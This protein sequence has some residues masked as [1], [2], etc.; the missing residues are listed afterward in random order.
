M[1]NRGIT[2]WPRTSSKQPSSTR[3]VA[4][5]RDQPSRR[6][7]LFGH[8]REETRKSIDKNGESST[9]PGDT[10][11]ER[12]AM[13]FPAMSRQL[14]TR[15]RKL[16]ADHRQLLLRCGSPSDFCPGLYTHT[17]IREAHACSARRHMAMLQQ[18]AVKTSRARARGA[19]R[20]HVTWRL[21]STRGGP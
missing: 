9:R 3:R 11:E 19:L 12:R 1:S 7:S 4:N 14:S 16:V 2:L 10:R 21:L 13:P 20:V 8:R 5:E 15:E 17:C 18:V 6:F